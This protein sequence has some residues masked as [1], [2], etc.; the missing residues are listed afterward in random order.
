MPVT[1]FLGIELA[2]IL[3]LLIVPLLVLWIVRRAQE[4]FEGLSSSVYS[5]YKIRL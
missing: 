3:M 5:N 4:E 1:P 2:P